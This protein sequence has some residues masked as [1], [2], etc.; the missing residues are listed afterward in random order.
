M[1]DRGNERAKQDLDKKRGYWGSYGCDRTDPDLVEAV[2]ILGERA[3]G[4]YAKL[5][6]VCIP[7]DVDW[8]IEEYDGYERIVEKHRTW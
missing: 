2:K 5:V 7:D 3:S 4:R 6:I 8:E 1:A